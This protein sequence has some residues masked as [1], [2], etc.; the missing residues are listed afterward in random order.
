MNKIVKCIEKPNE[1]EFVCTDVSVD[2][3]YQ[4]IME[5]DNDYKLYDDMGNLRYYTKCFF[6]EV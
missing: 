3:R 6:V 2:N 5:D 1:K 4:V